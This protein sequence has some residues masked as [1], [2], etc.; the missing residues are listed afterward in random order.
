[1]LVAVQHAATPICAWFKFVEALYIDAY[2]VY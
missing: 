2:A 1:V